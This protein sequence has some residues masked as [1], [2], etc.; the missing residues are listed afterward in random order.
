MAAGQ[1][2]LVVDPSDPGYS[3]QGTYYMS[4]TRYYMGVTTYYMSVTTYCMSV[5]RYYMS[6]LHVLYE[7]CQVLHDYTYY[8]SR[9]QERFRDSPSLR[10]LLG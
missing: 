10:I 2:I 9:W 5:T 7:R 6:V 4:V 8:S 3:A 1:D